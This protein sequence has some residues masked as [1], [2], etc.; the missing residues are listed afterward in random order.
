[1]AFS[2]QFEQLFGLLALAEVYVVDE[3]EIDFFAFLLPSLET[4]DHPLDPNR[5]PLVELSLQQLVD[6]DIFRVDLKPL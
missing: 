6:S 4:L 3:E 2:D 1:M 5:R